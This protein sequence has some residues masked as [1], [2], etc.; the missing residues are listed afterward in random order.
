MS[1]LGGYVFSSSLRSFIP[2]EI[3]DTM[4]GSDKKLFMSKVKAVGKTTWWIF[5]QILALLQED[6]GGLTLLQE[7]AADLFQDL[8]QC[9]V[10]VHDA[11]A[12]Y[13][14]KCYYLHAFS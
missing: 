3:V 13:L 14:S 4:A 5:K 1:E 12:Q 10:S 2:P 6:S 8:E 7:T 9:E 11:C